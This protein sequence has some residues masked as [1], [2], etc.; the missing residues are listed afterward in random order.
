MKTVQDDESMTAGEAAEFINAKI[1]EVEDI[2]HDPLHSYG[3]PYVS[4]WVLSYTIG[5]HTLLPPH[6]ITPRSTTHH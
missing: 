1:I 2:Y 5:N 6:T 4:P 3:L